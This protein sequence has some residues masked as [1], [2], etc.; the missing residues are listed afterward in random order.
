MNN[1]TSFEREE[2]Y[3]LFK[4][5]VIYFSIIIIIA[6]LTYVMLNRYTIV[7]AG[8]RSAYKINRI[9]GKTYFIAV[10]KEF[11]VEP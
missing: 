8:D 3:K 2:N 10:T 11:E 5:L 4:N 6:L 1:N 7:A 9:T